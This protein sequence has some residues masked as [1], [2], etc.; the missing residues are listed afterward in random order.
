VEEE[1]TS[2]ESDVDALS[3]LVSEAVSSPL[4]QGTTTVGGA[5]W[6]ITPDWQDDAAGLRMGASEDEAPGDRPDLGGPSALA[7]WG[8]ACEPQ[9]WTI[10]EEPVIPDQELAATQLPVLSEIS[11]GTPVQAAVA[12]L[13]S[14][15]EQEMREDL[16]LQVASET[17]ALKVEPEHAAT[18]GDHLSAPTQAKYKSSDILRTREADGGTSIAGLGVTILAAMEAGSKAATN[19]LNPDPLH[20]QH[21]AGAGA[22]PNL[23]MPEELA[24]GG[25]INLGEPQAYAALGSLPVPECEK[26]WTGTETLARFGEQDVA[27]LGVTILAAMRDQSTASHEV[28]PAMEAAEPVAD[29]APELPAATPDASVIAAGDERGQGRSS[30]SETASQPGTG[31]ALNRAALSHWNHD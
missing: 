5:G 28:G 23:K 14:L 16:E 19:R 18:Q 2:M 25:T 17:Q 21:A 10:E 15:I 12:S 31:I 8:K 7:E 9:V 20:T 22:L 29:S 13:V 4:L 3:D 1:E 30:Y 27:A 26:V 24:A 6:P 11:A